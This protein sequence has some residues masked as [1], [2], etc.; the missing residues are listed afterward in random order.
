MA[1]YSVLLVKGFTHGGKQSPETPKDVPSRGDNR[2]SANGAPEDATEACLSK[3]L[4]RLCDDLWDI[5]L[6]G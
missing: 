1:E 4:T 2:A 3:L 5:L 6:V